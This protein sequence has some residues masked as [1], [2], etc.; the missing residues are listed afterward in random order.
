MNIPAQLISFEDS[1]FFN[2]RRSFT[3]IYIDTEI[4]SKSINIDNKEIEDIY[5]QRKE[6]FVN[7]EKRDVEQL[8]FDNKNDAEKAFDSLKKGEPFSEVGKKTT[9]NDME[10]IS[11]SLVEKNQLLE[12]FAENVFLLKNNQ[13]TEPV[14]TD[15][16]WHILKVTKIIKE[17]IKPIKLV[18]DQIKKEIINDRSY[19]E[20]EIILEK[21]EDDLSKGNSLEDIAKKL[22]LKI[23]KRKLMEKKYFLNRNNPAIFSNKKFV[24]DIF[25]KEIDDNN[26]IIEI[27]NEDINFSFG[28]FIT[29]VDKIV[30]KTKKNFEEAFDDIFNKWSI[31]E[32]NTK[33]K[34]KVKKFNEKIEKNNFVNVCDELKIDN[35]IVDLVNK[36]ELFQQGF[37]EDFIK[38]LFKANKDEILELDTKQTYYLAK[39]T[40]VT[41]NIFDENDYD[42][43]KKNIEQ[44]VGVDNLEQL[45]YIMRKKF[46][47]KIN[48]KIFNSFISTIE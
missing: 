38:K 22:N 4:L 39:V 29:R 48:T 14:K 18:E 15:I 7:K 21:F 3:Y 44:E 27:E 34:N 28:F 40:S 24:K 1:F 17:E 45:G 25:E 26:F 8:V 2:E 13:F 12:E 5:N 36:N 19:D 30:K 33:V 11:F 10:V 35:R 23:G 37:P 31:I 43:I 6:E 16:G 42:K 20:L 46:P 9:G 32:A 41:K 47:I